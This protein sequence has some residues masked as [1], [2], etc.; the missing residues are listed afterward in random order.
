M[1]TPTET[2]TS[3]HVHPY[4]HTH[5]KK[6]KK[7][8]VINRFI[9][10]PLHSLSDEILKIKAELFLLQCCYLTL[11]RMRIVDSWVFLVG[12]ITWLLYKILSLQT[13]DF[14]TLG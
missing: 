12:K 1:C 9:P 7:L 5:T 2:L 11:E 4:K 3:T 10:I 8:T 6:E 14:S 13:L